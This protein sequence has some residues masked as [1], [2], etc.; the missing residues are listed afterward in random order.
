MAELASDC[1]IIFGP[2]LKLQELQAVSQTCRALRACVKDLAPSTW[3][4]STIR[5]VPFYHPLAR[6]ADGDRR[7]LLVCGNRDIPSAARQLWEA[8]A[9]LQCGRITGT[10]VSTEG[11][12]TLL[13]LQPDQVRGLC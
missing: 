9:G 13:M 1:F 8:Y 5:T 3:R 10:C 4:E 11:R 7:K 6:P 2:V 12:L